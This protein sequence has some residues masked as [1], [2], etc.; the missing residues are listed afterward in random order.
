M[1][2]KYL[3]LILKLVPIPLVLLPVPGKEFCIVWLRGA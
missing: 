2:K 3:G 1:R